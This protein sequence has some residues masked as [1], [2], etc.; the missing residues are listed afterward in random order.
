MGDISH[1]LEVIR[2]FGRFCGKYPEFNFAFKLQYRDLDTFV[3]PS[4]KGRLDVKYIKRFEETR[5]SRGQFD[6]LVS[7]IR[8][9]GFYV[10]ATPFDNASVDVIDS[11]G[12]DIIK[13]ASCSFTDWHLL[14]RVAQSKLPVIASTAGASLSEIDRVVSFFSHRNKDFAILHC[15]GEYPTP[16]ENLNLDQIDSLMERYP[17]VR[18]GFSTHE[19]P[20]STDIVKMAI[21]KGVS[22][23]EKHVGVHTSEYPIN[24]YSATPSQIDAWLTAARFA[25]KVCGNAVRNPNKNKAELESLRALRRGLFARR[26]IRA[27]EVLSVD[28]IYFA[29]PPD[30]TQFTAS[31]WSKYA[32][33]VV[34]SDIEKDGAL[35]PENT[36]IKDERELVLNVARKVKELIR[37]SGIV[38]PGGVELEISHHYGLERFQEVGLTMLTVVNRSYCKKILVSLPGQK[39][40]EQFHKQKEETF[41]I[42]YGEV[43]ISLDGS[44]LTYRAGDVITIEPGVRHA[45]CSKDGCIIEEISSTHYKNDSFYTDETIQENK[46]RKTV[47]T[48]WMD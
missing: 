11:Q 42:L 34:T 33:F 21:A 45:F 44:S 18:I 20:E 27:G 29:F 41:N 2:Q 13:I 15:V 8:E 37:K 19:N 4:M 35:K 31:D 43:E 40:P 26:P 22:I 12:L 6:Q 48:Y 1:G 32:R 36:E 46:N 47:L 10:I 38:V 30:G 3:H 9:Q 5:L 14:E 39:H 23:F 16:D 24:G 28:D 25:K 17:D 7:E